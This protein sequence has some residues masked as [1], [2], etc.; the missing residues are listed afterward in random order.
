MGGEFLRV[1]HQAHTLFDN[2][3]HGSAIK[4]Q[5]VFIANHSGNHPGVEHV[6]FWV[7]LETRFKICRNFKQ[8]SEVWVVGMQHVV[9]H[10]IAE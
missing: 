10:A 6:I 9:E 8:L 7:S 5:Q 3:G 2:G 1:I 4:G